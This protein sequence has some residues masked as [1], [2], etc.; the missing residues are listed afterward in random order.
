MWYRTE[1]A[2][3]GNRKDQG[4]VDTADDGG[5]GSG[6][7]WTLSRQLSGG[8]RK[9]GRTCGALAADPKILLLDE[10]FGAL[11]AITRSVLQDELLKVH[12]EMRKTFLLRPMT[13]TKH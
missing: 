11:D 5:A 3:M 6:A 10:P 7:I 9:V 12:Q 8:Q 13:S 4:R 1:D 2:E